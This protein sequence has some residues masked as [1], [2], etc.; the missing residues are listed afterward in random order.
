MARVKLNI[1]L[2]NVRTFMSRTQA[3]IFDDFYDPCQ[4]MNAK[5]LMSKHGRE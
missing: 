3:S 1:Q 2:T 4:K 5:K